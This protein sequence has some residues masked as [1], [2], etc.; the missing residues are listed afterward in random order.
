MLAGILTVVGCGGEPQAPPEP[1]A[2]GAPAEPSVSQAPSSP[3]PEPVPE[4]RAVPAWPPVDATR[5][6][7]ASGRRFIDTEGREILLH[8]VNVVDKSPERNYLS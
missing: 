4:T 3:L 7:T 1:L 6:I 5:F 2:P 8:G